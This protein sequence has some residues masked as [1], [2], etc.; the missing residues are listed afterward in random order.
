MS[1]R[2]RIVPPIYFFASL[3]AMVALHAYLPVNAVVPSPFDLVGGLLVALGL[4]STL[5]AAGLFRNA[6]TP[7][8]PFRQSTMLVISGVYRITR[9]PMYLGM[10]LVLLGVALLLGT[11]AAFFPIPLFVWQIQRKFVLPEEAF[12]EGLFGQQYVEYKSRVRRW[13]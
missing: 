3:L 11:I 7:I 5:W 4:C 2:H 13:L 10:A 1:N 9:N 8:R 12:L 6:G